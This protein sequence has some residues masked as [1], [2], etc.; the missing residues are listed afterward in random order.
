[1]LLK[2]VPSINTPLATPRSGFFVRF[3]ADETTFI[4]DGSRAGKPEGRLTR[5]PVATS[6]FEVFARNRESSVRACQHQR[7]LRMTDE[8]IRWHLPGFD[9]GQIVSVNP[10]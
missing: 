3:S 8:L 1:M 4:R 10:S 6:G 9:S 7:F 2:Q 5:P